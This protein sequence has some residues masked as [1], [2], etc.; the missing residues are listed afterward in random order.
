[1]DLNLLGEIASIADVPVIASGGIGCVS[2]IIKA[3]ETGIDAIALAHV[4]HYNQISLS[5]IKDSL[6]KSDLFEVRH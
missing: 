6:S 3:A 5:E 1:M 4:L 2:D